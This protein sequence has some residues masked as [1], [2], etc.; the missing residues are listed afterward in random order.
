DQ[1]VIGARIKPG[2]LVV[3]AV[4][5]GEH[6]HRGLLARLVAQLAAN[7]EA[8]HAGQV[9]IEDDRIEVVHHRQVQ[10]GDPVGREVDRM[11]ALLEIVAK[12]GGDVLVVLD[13]E[14]A[15][16]RW[17]PGGWLDGPPRTRGRTARD[18]R[19]LAHNRAKPAFAGMPRTQKTRD[20]PGPRDQRPD[21]RNPL[22]GPWP[23]TWR[24]RCGNHTLRGR[25][26]NVR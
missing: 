12:V 22:A 16:R 14:Y 3:Q 1:V 4:A 20:M 6:Q 18:G 7:L 5:G 19:I 8:V 26:L 24:A 23:G 13:D 15:H 10:A 9:E 21:R 25:R 11:A 2:Q 17:L